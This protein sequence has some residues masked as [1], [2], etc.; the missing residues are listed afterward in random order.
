[1]KSKMRAPHFFLLILIILG[2]ALL[3]TRGYWA[4]YLTGEAGETLPHEESSAVVP[5]VPAITNRSV[6]EPVQPPEPSPSGV[7]GI[8]MIGPTCPVE[9][10]DDDGKCDDKPFQTILVIT[11]DVPGRG[12]VV[13]ASDSQGRFSQNLVQGT[14]TI[15][16][17]SD[18][19]MPS[20][21]PVTF[22][23]RKQQRTQLTLEFDS[24][25]R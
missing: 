10:S 15:R 14:Y 7:Y 21:A 9:R 2:A 17:Q 12:N 13:V 22:V 3:V 1:M 23:V 20:L 25:I 8:V 18:V 6:D 16:A 24:G 19:L 5:V 11:S 4:P